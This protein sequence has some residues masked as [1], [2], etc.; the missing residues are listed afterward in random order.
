RSR[1]KRPGVIGEEGKARRIRH[2]VYVRRLLDR[3][4]HENAADRNFEL[5]AGEGHGNVGRLDYLVRNV[6]GRELRADLPNDRGAHVVVQRRIAERLDEQRDKGLAAR[7]ID[8]DHERLFH[9][10]K[11]LDSAIDFRR[12]YAHAAAIERRI[13]TPEYEAAATRI[14]TEKISVTP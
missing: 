6:P 10:R 7:R 1:R 8:M 3:R 2:C 4:A 9:E 12:A 5:L 14:H 13:R 11:R